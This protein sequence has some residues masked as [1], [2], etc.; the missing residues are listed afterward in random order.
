MHIHSLAK[1]VGERG[2]YAMFVRRLTSLIKRDITYLY[3]QQ[4]KKPLKD[5]PGKKKSF[6]CTSN[7][8]MLLYFDSGSVFYTAV[9]I[10]LMTQVA[11]D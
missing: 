1:A 7:A 3:E 8:L 10:N 9:L 11:V 5:C 4:N 6:V 2:P